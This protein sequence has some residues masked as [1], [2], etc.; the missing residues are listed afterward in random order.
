MPQTY[1]S[2]LKLSSRY[3]G[4]SLSLTS[5]GEPTCT[6][7]GV[8][9]ALNRYN[10]CQEQGAYFPNVNLFTNGIL[11]GDEGFCYEYLPIWKN[12]GLTAI[13]VSIHSSKRV[14]QETVYRRKYP[15]LKIIFRNIRKYNLQCR[16]TILLRKG[17]ID[18]PQEYSKAINKIITLGC[19]N[20][21]SWSIGNPDGT[22][23]EYTPSHY[24]LV[25]IRYW[26]WRNTKKSHGH[27]WGGGV[28]DYNNTLIRLTD[29]VTKHKPNRNYVRQLVVFP[30]GDVNYSWIRR[31]SLCFKV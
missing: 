7:N 19:K 14:G 28:Y 9:N 20:I 6:P 18:T 2:A 12:L 21:T 13:A 29:Y 25:K 22:R 30:D 3:G 8:T 11:L 15:E 5:G 10:K 27:V 23:N 26:L 16:A 17:G 24:N 31:G 1:E 4:W